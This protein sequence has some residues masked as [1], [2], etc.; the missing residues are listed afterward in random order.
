MRLTWC[1]ARCHTDADQGTLSGAD[2]AACRLPW[3]PLDPGANRV[4]GSLL[5]NP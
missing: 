2:P 1:A 3:L 4:L 5:L